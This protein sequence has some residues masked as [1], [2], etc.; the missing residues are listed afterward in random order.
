MKTHRPFVRTLDRI[1][2][3]S[4][5]GLVVCILLCSLFIWYILL[6]PVLPVPQN[7]QEISHEEFVSGPDHLSYVTDY[8]VADTIEAVQAYYTALGAACDLSTCHG[9]TF[10][11]RG[12][13][14]VHLRKSGNLI[15]IDGYV[16][17]NA[18]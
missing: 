9:S 3:I 17:W 14:T 2:L 8:I 16:V 15:R 7:A 18:P 10:L 11:H 12:H 4:L 13:Y 5:S 1:M 6:T